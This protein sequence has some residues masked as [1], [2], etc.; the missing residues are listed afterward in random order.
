MLKCSRCFSGI[1]ITFLL[2]AVFP[3]FGRDVEIYVEDRDL[4]IPLEGA[5]IRSWDGTEYECDEDGKVFI[6]VPDDRQ[7]VVQGAYPGYENNRLVIS[8]GTDHFTLALRLSGIME[9]RELV[10]EASRPGVSESRSGRSVAISGPELARTA[11]IGIIEDVMTSIKLLPGVGYSGMFNAM[12]SIRGGDPG[13]LEAVLDGFYLARPYHWGGGVSIFDPKMISSAQLSHGVFSTRYGHTISGLLEITSKKADPTEMELDVGL[14]TSAASINLSYPLFGKGGIMFMGK[15]T[16]WDLLVWTA[17][18]ISKAAPGNETLDLINAVSTAPYIRSAALSA[19]Y[20]FN[21][22]LE[23]TLNGFFGSDGIGAEYI[24]DYDEDGLLGDDGISG[25]M[26]MNFDYHN[27]QGFGIAGLTFN[28]MPTMALKATAG[29]GYTELIAEGL[30]NNDVE[31]SYNPIFVTRYS[32][33]FTSTPP[34]PRP[35]LPPTGTYHAPDLKMGIDS[36]NL[37]FNAQARFDM[38]W[39]LGNGFLAAAGVQELYTNWRQYENVDLFMERS[40]WDFVNNVSI[41]NPKYDQLA[42]YGSDY[43]AVIW[44]FQKIVDVNNHG[45]FTSAY[46]LMEYTT[47]NQFFG[48]EAGIRMDQLYFAGKGFTVS[49]VPAWSPRLNLDFNILKN[50]ELFG[51]PNFL[52]SL[53]ATIGTGL[54]SS[55]NENISFIEEGND[56]LENLKLNRSWTTVIG[57]KLD[58]AGGFSFNIEGYYKQVFNRAYIMADITG[59]SAD[60]VNVKWGFDGEGRIWGFDLQLQKMQS[61]YIDGWISYTFTHARYYEPSNSEYGVDG[62]SGIGE[63]EEENDWYYPSFHRFHNFNLVLNIKPVRRFNIALR[64]GFASGQPRREITYSEVFAY[65]VQQVE[66]NEA[67][68]K[69]E[70]VLE[71][72]KQVIIQK[73]GRTPIKREETRGVWSLP[74]DLKFSFFIFDRKGRVQTE[75]YLGVENLLSLVYNPQRVSTTYN[76]YT[77]KEDTGSNSVSYDLPIPMVSFGFKWSY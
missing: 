27:Y 5:L 72:G 50:K 26:S 32:S 20:R 3:L 73:F 70:P 58:F 12:P 4:E 42:V 14:S 59:N 30:V 7:V 8:L 47:P 13:D 17:Q 23:L 11:E 19:N 54:F 33:L 9:N 39:D 49:A 29:L 44:P 67:T 10:I 43:A 25:N 51:I 71:D 76:E 16:Y 22:D 28:P 60:S 6:S 75:I 74:L 53:S 35:I 18:G 52:E 57:T 65:P 31:V 62:V 36:D 45:L 63:E 21:T 77:G 68:G 34:F 61:R 24:T 2:A 37:V 48:V 38:D 46:T 66:W 56:G 41:V 69:Y 1:F 15:V 64:F 55:M 40:L